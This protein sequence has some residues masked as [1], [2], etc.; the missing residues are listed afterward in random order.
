MFKEA[1]GLTDWEPSEARIAENTNS[2]CAGTHSTENE[3]RMIWDI[4]EEND[5]KQV[6]GVK[7]VICGCRGI[8]QN[9]S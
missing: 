9:N 4:C 5:N 3:E 6:R 1:S 2:I 8:L 7:Q